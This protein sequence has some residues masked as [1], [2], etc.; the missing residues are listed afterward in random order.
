MDNKSNCSPRREKDGT[1]S[2]PIDKIARTIYECHAKKATENL[3]QFLSKIGFDR[4]PC[5]M[6]FDE[7]DSL[8]MLFWVLLRL[9]NI[10]ED[11]KAMW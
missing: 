2:F 10:Q 7:A 9:L 6:Y 11:S 3:V 8:N 1:T 5:V 4:A